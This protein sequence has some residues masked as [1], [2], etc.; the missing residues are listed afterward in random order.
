MRKVIF[1]S[2]ISL[3]GFIEGPGGELDWLQQGQDAVDISAFL[4][5]FDTIF[6]GRKTY[7][8]IGVPKRK[9][10]RMGSKE[11]RFLLAVE[12]MRKYVFT[13]TMKHVEGNAMVIG[14]NLE[15]EVKRIREEEGKNIWLC[16]GADI[17]RTFARFDLVDEYFLSV[18]PI[19]LAAGKPLFEGLRIPSN[20]KLVNRQK[21][22]S[23][24]L[25]LQY[26]PES[27]LNTICYDSRGI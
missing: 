3:D 25:I 8:K 7:D 21:L 17:L 24:V 16:G 18:H 10:A 9:D 4:S 20:L 19:I 14:D 15:V 5:S 2:S 26:I 1:E 22:K 23:G 12:G 13:R 11:E 27:R 6:Y